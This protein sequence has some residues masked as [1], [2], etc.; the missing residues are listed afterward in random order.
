MP[1][2]LANMNNYIIVPS[3]YLKYIT[4]NNN[5][6]YTEPDITKFILYES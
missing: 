1:V 3:I 5:V 2:N 6:T 4:R